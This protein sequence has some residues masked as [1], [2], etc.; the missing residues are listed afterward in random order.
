MG[1]EDKIRYECKECGEKFYSD[2]PV[3]DLECPKCTAIHVSP[4]F[5]GEEKE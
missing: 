3:I 1:K 5:P 2:A 4:I